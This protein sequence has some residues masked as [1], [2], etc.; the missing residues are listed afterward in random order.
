[1]RE[2]RVFKNYRKDESDF[3]KI[4]IFHG[5]FQDHVEFESGLGHTVV[6]IVEYDDGNVNIVDANQIQFI[7][8]K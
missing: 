1:M 5:F 4:A 3:I 6:A 2:C 7:V 8:Q